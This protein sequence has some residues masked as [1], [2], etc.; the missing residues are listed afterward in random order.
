MILLFGCV[1]CSVPVCIPNIKNVPN[2]H[3]HAHTGKEREKNVGFSH[4]HSNTS[5]NRN[6]AYN[7]YLEL[8]ECSHAH[9]I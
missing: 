3:T 5:G 6:S 9:V 8:K 2:S 1:V 4:R 7:C